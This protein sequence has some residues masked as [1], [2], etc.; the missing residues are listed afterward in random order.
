M[1]VWDTPA[2]ARLRGLVEFLEEARK[3]GDNKSLLTKR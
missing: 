2:K 3:D 1:V